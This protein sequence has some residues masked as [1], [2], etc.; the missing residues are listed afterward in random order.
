MPENPDELVDALAVAVRAGDD[1]CI[2]VLLNPLKEVA[3]NRA[4]VAARHP[5][6]ALLHR[7]DARVGLAADY[8][9]V[10]AWLRDRTGG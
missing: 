3:G 8:L 7:V 5:G 10:A 6:D 9:A 1:R 2:G 4:W